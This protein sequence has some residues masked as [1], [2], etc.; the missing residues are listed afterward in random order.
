MDLC[1]GCGFDYDLTLAPAA[2]RA[3]ADGAGELAGLVV[4]APDAARRLHP[5]LWS[6]LEYECHVR[7]V[8]LVQRERVL[9]A[10]RMDCPSVEPMGREERAEHDGYAEQDPERVARELVD[11]AFMF[12]NVLDRLDADGWERTLMYNYPA[13]CERSL[14]W[15]AV[16][17]E[18]EVKHHLLDVRNQL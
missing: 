3:I 4:A 8:L 2:A 10:R 15:I 12:A 17:T 13:L 7:D 16:H 9:A 5:D 14:R 6:P 11:A 18:H 1:A